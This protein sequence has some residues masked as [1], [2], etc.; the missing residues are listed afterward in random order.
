MAEP[1]AFR[2]GRTRDGFPRSPM[3]WRP[4]A[5]GAAAFVLSLLLRPAGAL[6]GA[7]AGRN[8]RREPAPSPRP[9]IGVGSPVA[10]GAG[11][12]P[13]ALALGRAAR[14][15]GLVPGF[16]TRGHG[17]EATDPRAPLLVDPSRHTAR[18]AGD[19]PLLLAALGPTVACADRAAGA[20]LLAPLCD[21]IVMDDGFQSRRLRADVWLLVVDGARGVGNGRCLP[22]GPLRAPLRRQLAAADALLTIDSGQGTAGAAPVEV[23]A[24]A[25]GLPVHRGWME[26]RGDWRGREVAAFCGLA[27]PGKF[28]RTLERAGARVRAFRA[29]PDHHPF[30]PRDLEAVAAMAGDLP[31]VTTAKDAARLGP[32]APPHDVLRIELRLEDGAADALIAAAVDGYERSALRSARKDASASL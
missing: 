23:L 7:V 30:T 17:R 29:F 4:D 14:A 16:L 25:R 20:A 3:P 10:G 21:L 11:K 22:A 2:A 32:G 31:L 26:A 6:Y 24:R 8:L 27:D 12:T 18:E 15:A 5:G 13:T 1:A 28:R 19:E 9:T